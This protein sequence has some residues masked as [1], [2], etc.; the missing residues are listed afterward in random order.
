MFMVQ[1]CAPAL[2]LHQIS[3]AIVMG[4]L[5]MAVPKN[6]YWQTWFTSIYLTGRDDAGAR[7]GLSLYILYK[8]GEWSAMLI[9][10]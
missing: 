10:G 1:V 8:V 5:I 6:L 2:C 7:L 4:G 9:Q 3:I